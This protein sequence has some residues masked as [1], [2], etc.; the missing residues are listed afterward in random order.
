MFI[1]TQAIEKELQ[2]LKD[3]VVQ[4]QQQL[5]RERE[6][7]VAR[8]RE[9]KQREKEREQERERERERERAREKESA[10]ES[11]RGAGH[12][13]QSDA[14]VHDR[15]A[16]TGEGGGIDRGGGGA[17]AGSEEMGGRRVE[18]KIQSV[19]SSSIEKERGGA[20][21]SVDV[22]GEVGSGSGRRGIGG[23]EGKEV[24]CDVKAEEDAT[25]VRI[26]GGGRGPD[27]GGWGGWEMECMDRSAVLTNSSAERLRI[28]KALLS[29]W[30]V[31]VSLTVAYA[32]GFPFRVCMRVCVF[33]SVW[34]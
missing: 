5:E 21:G 9:R 16:T 27:G 24:K 19:L 31:S 2:H 17:G 4:Q 34:M 14:S 26:A 13:R 22:S 6:L 8:S 30:C 29:A 15:D 33:L 18:N 7:E 11:E 32:R 23:R 1:F 20:A 12:K 28:V 3:K 25:D 10:R